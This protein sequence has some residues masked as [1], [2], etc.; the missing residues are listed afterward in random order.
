M[1]SIGRHLRLVGIGAIVIAMPP[2]AS[3]SIRGTADDARLKWA[4]TSA[5]SA[6][7]PEHTSGKR[8]SGFDHAIWRGLPSR[9]EVQR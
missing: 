6:D 4:L 5:I 3:A 7:Q 2:L 8:R 1:N 9:H